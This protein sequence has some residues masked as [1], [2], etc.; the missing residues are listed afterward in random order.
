MREDSI[1]DYMSL[2][3][4]SQFTIKYIVIICYTFPQEMALT[5]AEKQKRYRERRDKDDQRKAEHK[6]KCRQK[7]KRDLDEGKRKQYPI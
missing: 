6:K 2:N 3:Y 7:Y 5:N 1:Y 4:S